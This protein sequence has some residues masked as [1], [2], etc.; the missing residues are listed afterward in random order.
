[1]KDKTMLDFLKRH[2]ADYQRW[3]AFCLENDAEPGDFPTFVGRANRCAEFMQRQGRNRW[4]KC[5]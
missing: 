5:L 3:R 1:M 4:R 2:P